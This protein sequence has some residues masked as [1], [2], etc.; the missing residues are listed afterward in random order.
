M[1]LTIC[2]LTKGRKE[3]LKDALESYE[4]FLD[5]G[6]VDVILIDNGS[7]SASKQ[8]LLDWK[9]KY[10]K[11]VSYFRNETN[12]PAGFTVF[13]EIIG[14]FNPE[15]IL[16]PGDDDILVFDVY[17]KWVNALEENPLLN[18][19]A[20]SALLI[21]SF[22][23]ETGEI[24]SPAVNMITNPAEMIAR[25]LNEPPFFWPS[26]FF[27]FSA[28]PTPVLISR[29]AHDWWIGLHLVIKG[30]IQSTL[31][32]GVKYR[33]HTGQESFQASNRRKFFEGYNMLTSFIKSP[34][35]QQVLGSLSGLE[36]EKLID[37][38]NKT[39]PLYAQPEYFISL[40]KDLIL[41]VIKASKSTSVNTKMSEKY[42]LSAGIYT[43][44]YDLEN[45]YT[46]LNLNT[47]RSSGNFAL[48]FAESVCKDLYSVKNFFNE[49]ATTKI[50]VSCKHSKL[51][52]G[53]ILIN[54]DKFTYLNEIEISD[55]VLIS[56]NEHLEN[57]GVLNFTVLPFEKALILFYRKFKLR[58]P[59]V[60]KKYLFNLKK[61]ISGGK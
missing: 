39:K 31:N 58:F 7:D 1:K 5:T 20:S 28:L 15:W 24:K 3:Y 40:M 10:D 37:L 55:S 4:K 6:K 9:L 46:G 61:F 23:K 53:S 17:E 25:S 27:R 16:N 59:K 54:C 18:A 44:K 50:L 52:S 57:S 35:F 29:F 51:S 41:S 30:Q 48:F 14:S 38:C 26:L 22:G 13:W 11:K 21:D 36:K 47:E 45:I 2:L 8:I 49:T 32:V 19:F 42:V 12:N 56:I 34:E 33:V 43:K 60:F